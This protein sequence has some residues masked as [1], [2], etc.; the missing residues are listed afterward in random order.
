MIVSTET[1]G[2]GNRIKSWV[3]AMR[4]DADA[5]VLWPVTPN[6][7]ARFADLFTNAI[8]VES[9]PAG[10]IEYKSWRLAVPDE[11]AACLP[12]GFGVVGA[13][14]HPL[15]RGIAKAW[16]QVRGRPDDRY[17]YMLFPKQHSR[18]STRADARHI[19]LEYGRIP[20][21]IRAR[22][23]AVFRQVH[24]RPEIL[25]LADAWADSH[26]LGNVI[27]VQVRTWRDEPRRYRKYHLPARRRLLALM[28][29]V[30]DESRFL[31]VSDSDEM[32]ELLAGEF[33]D[34][35]V[36][37]FPRTTKRAESWH[38]V[39]GVTEDLLDMLLLSRVR[40]LFA[41]YLSTF[42]EA[43]WWLGGAQAEVSVF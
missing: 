43:A 19:D 18:R 14:A 20:P 7:P 32:I 13:G 37:S 4:L 9:L 36:L 31:V 35:R 39:E 2:L 1:G 15:L 26:M 27:G 22:Y 10:A 17:R 28:R 33:G 41:S 30:S 23:T 8:A 3:S 38:S 21:P 6:M 25:A 42:S 24:I 29:A 16:W 5:R 11:D 34:A 12:R 40:T